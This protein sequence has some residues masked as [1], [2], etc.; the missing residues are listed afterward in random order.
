MGR[1]ATDVA[2]ADCN[3]AQLRLAALIHVKIAT[4]PHLAYVAHRYAGVGIL[5]AGIP[6]RRG[7]SLR[8]RHAESRVSR[9]FVAIRSHSYALR[10]RRTENANAVQP[11]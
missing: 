8:G 3:S 9:H 11:A 1:T 5:S 2:P 4:E 6:D 7:A 10:C